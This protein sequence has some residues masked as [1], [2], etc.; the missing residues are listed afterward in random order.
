LADD[1]REQVERRILPP[2]AQ[3]APAS[4]KEVDTRARC[5]VEET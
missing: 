2:H 5:L 3:R 4:R 1:W